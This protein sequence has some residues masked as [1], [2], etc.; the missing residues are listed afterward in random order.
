MRLA[1]ALHQHLPGSGNV[2]MNLPLDL[3]LD[4]VFWAAAVGAGHPR[5]GAEQ[6]ADQRALGVHLAA[7]R[8]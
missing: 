6:P 2:V 8:A 1:P 3:R 4:H 7:I 5:R